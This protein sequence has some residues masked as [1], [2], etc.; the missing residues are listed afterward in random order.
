MTRDEI[1]DHLAKVYLGKKENKEVEEVKEPIKPPEPKKNPSWL[2]INVAI[3]VILLISVVYGFTAFFAKRSDVAS[4][5]QYSLN[6]G[7]LRVNYDLNEPYPATKTYVIT[8][9]QKDVTKFKQLNFSI[10]GMIDAYPG[11]VKMVVSNKKNE[12]ALYYVKNVD[13]QWQKITVPFERLNLTDWSNIT[14]VAF[15]LEGWN[16]DYRKGTMMI[17]DISFSN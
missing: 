14:E 7:L 13:G 4:Q 6:N 15:V 8:I 16:V 17:D 1:Y 3:T 11:V 2:M 5:V 9:P 12:K 10:R